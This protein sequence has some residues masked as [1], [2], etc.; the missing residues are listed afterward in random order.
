MSRGDIDCAQKHD[1]DVPSK[2]REFHSL[3]FYYKNRIFR[4]IVCGIN[5][6]FVVLAT[7]WQLAG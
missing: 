2:I 1:G 6:R 7:C 5:E 3:V 4:Q